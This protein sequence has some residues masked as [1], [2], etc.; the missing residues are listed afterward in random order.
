MKLIRE[1]KLTKPISKMIT[2]AAASL[3]TLLAQT[4]VHL[5]RQLPVNFA[6]AVSIA[7]NESL[8]IR[9]SASALVAMCSFLFLMNPSM[10]SVGLI[11]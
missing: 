6:F 8:R 11:W 10:F 9:L 5:L 1:R 3:L 7:A 4:M 2:A